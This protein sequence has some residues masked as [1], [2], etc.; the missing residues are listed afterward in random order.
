[1]GFRFSIENGFTFNESD[2]ERYRREKWKSQDYR[3]GYR[4]FSDSLLTLYTNLSNREDLDASPA[5][6]DFLDGLWE[7]YL[8]AKSKLEDNIKKGGEE[9]DQE[10]IEWQE[11][12]Q[13]GLIAVHR[14]ILATL[15]GYNETIP[16]PE[17]RSKT[18]A[19][20]YK[21]AKAAATSA[22]LEAIVDAHRLLL[23]Q[24]KNKRATEDEVEEE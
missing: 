20:G 12:Y 17:G 21:V 4:Y 10:L 11:G 22:I 6:C 18:Y 1:M 3:V 8:E 23:N 15:K 14:T 24:F 7:A 13:D 19:R 9:M 16:L 2:L 5:S